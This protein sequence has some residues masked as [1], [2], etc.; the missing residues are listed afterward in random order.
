MSS[1]TAME[2]N[3]PRPKSI[4]FQEALG[5]WPLSKR[6]VQ[7]LIVGGGKLTRREHSFRAASNRCDSA[8]SPVAKQAM[9]SEAQA[10]RPAERQPSVMR[11][12]MVGLS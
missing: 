11:A 6:R 7:V 5:K 3:S 4:L 8:P 2:V 9:P 12:D 1:E 10:F